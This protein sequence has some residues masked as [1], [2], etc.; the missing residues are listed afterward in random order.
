MSIISCIYVIE[1]LVN[2]K[3]YVGSAVNMSKR[4]TLHLSHLRHQK[5]HS[6]HLQNA[7]NK[8]GESNF[9]FKVLEYCQPEDLITIEQ[10]YLDWLEPEY[11]ICKLARSCRGIK[12]TPEHKH[13][14]SLANKGNCNFR[15]HT[16][17]EEAKHK[18]GEAHLGNTNRL[19]QKNSLEHN[20][21][22]S[23]A[24]KEQVPWIKGRGHSKETRQKLSEALKGKRNALG[25]KQSPKTIQKRV[26]SLR[27]TLQAKKLQLQAGK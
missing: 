20:L 27:L 26:A 17:T 9:N 3:L 15:G 25:N 19:G 22:I 4:W 1:N 13:K 5:H 16:H 21:K 12:L 23:L 7:W 10:Y 18:I 8:Y 6:K 2:N 24:N 14:I 11:N